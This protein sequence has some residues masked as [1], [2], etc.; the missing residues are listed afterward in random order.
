MFYMNIIEQ[1][2]QEIVLYCI[3]NNTVLSPIE[4]QEMF[5]DIYEKVECSLTN[6]PKLKE[7]K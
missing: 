2:R 6:P 4:Y 3:S 5:K 1:V 7:V